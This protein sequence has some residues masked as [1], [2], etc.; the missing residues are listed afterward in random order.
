VDGRG[1]S[2][3]KPEKIGVNPLY[4]RSI[5]PYTDVIIALTIQKVSQADNGACPPKF[6][7]Q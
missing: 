5:N 3:I 6:A 2:R 4:P 7:V 1:S